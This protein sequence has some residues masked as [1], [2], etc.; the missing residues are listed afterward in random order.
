M[1]GLNIKIKWLV[2]LWVLLVAM[3][4][5]RFDRKDFLGIRKISSY[6][7]GTLGDAY[8]YL[9]H[10]RYFRGE[11]GNELLRSPYS[12]RPFP[13]ALAAPLP[14]SPMTSINILNLAV[15]LISL[16]Y[17][18]RVLKHLD[19]CP[20]TCF[21]GALLYI[22]SFPTL[23]YSTIG[24]IDPFLVLV[25]LIGVDLILTK[26]N[27]AIILLSI[28]SAGI[29]EKFVIIF[30]F[31]LLYDLWI[32]KKRFFPTVLTV[33]LTGIGFFACYKIIQYVT[34]S[35][36]YGWYFNWQAVVENLLRPRAWLS[37]LLTWGP[38][39][40]LITLYFLKFFKVSFQDRKIFSFWVGTAAGLSVWVYGFITVYADGR[41][42]WICYP[43]MVPLF[44][45]Y[46]EGYGKQSSKVK[47]VLASVIA[48]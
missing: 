47:K 21:L 15:M 40:L 3:A 48:R 39:G 8:Y 32:H 23:Y 25:L 1:L 34:P 27:A 42:I 22:F 24:Y 43:F 9:N 33:V 11:G 4:L 41:Y 44:C 2:V 16:I 6:G 19:F 45:L 10:I 31:W 12:F 20:E 37:L 30:P 18:L 14:F 38:L 28:L 7:K 29:N 17:L 5:P 36:D 26:Q 46:F 13:L 35:S